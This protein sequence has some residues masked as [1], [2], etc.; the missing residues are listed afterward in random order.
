[1]GSRLFEDLDYQLWVLIQQTRDVVTKVRE[2]EMAKHGL[3]FIQS[4]VMFVINSNG[5]QAT[6]ANI[7]DWLL[8]EQHTVSS[9][10]SRMTRD[11]LVYK[12]KNRARHGELTVGLTEKGKEALKN[13]ENIETIKGLLSVIPEEDRQRL[14]SQLK[15]VRDKALTYLSLEKTA[16]YP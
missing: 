14:F 3:T 7:S 13:I 6:S 12:V 5:G 16:P 15:S 2:R 4:A 11:G 9:T 8:R 10:L 1:M